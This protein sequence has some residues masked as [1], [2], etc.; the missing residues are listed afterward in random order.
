MPTWLTPS[1]LS[2]VPAVMPDPGTLNSLAST[3]ILVPSK[4]PLTFFCAVRWLVFGI[5][6]LSCRT[7][8][9]LLKGVLCLDCATQYCFLS[10]LMNISLNTVKKYFGMSACMHAWIKLLPKRMVLCFDNKSWIRYW[11]LFSHEKTIWKNMRFLSL[12]DV[13]YVVITFWTKKV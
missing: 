13:H 9:L 8:A 2:S 11:G 7:W 10:A 1:F 3:F 5:S 6:C 4:V 12:E